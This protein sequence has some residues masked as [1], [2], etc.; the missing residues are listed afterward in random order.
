M[1]TDNRKIAKYA[2]KFI[3]GTP[4]AERYYD[5]QETHAVDIMTSR[6]GKLKNRVVYATIGLHRKDLGLNYGSVPLRTELIMAASKDQDRNKNIIADAAFYAMNSE[7]FAYGAI[8][9]DVIGNRIP[10]ASVKHAVCLSP[11]F[12]KDYAPLQTEDETVAWLQLV[13]VTDQEMEF[14]TAVGLDDFDRLLEESGADITDFSRKSI[15]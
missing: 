3:G 8:I 14:I 13:P 7:G 5:Q 4:E 10:S 12:W 1:M 9:P 6:G 11:V 15:I 2:L